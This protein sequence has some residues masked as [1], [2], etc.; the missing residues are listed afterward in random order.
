MSA[1]RSHSLTFPMTVTLRARSAEETAALARTVAPLLHPGDVLL[2]EGDI[3]AG[4]T[5]FAR[6]LIQERLRL[7]GEAVEDVPSPTFTLVQAYQ[8]G[9]DE[10]WH[11]DLY[12]LSDPDEAVELGLEDAFS[13]AICLVEWP[14][15]LGDLVP[16]DAAVLQFTS[17]ETEDRR[18]LAVRFPAARW[19]ACAKALGALA[20]TQ[21]QCQ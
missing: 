21:D 2:L 14:D 8:A 1:A 9:Q 6:A 20:D 16:E 19:A 18:N 13:T 15:R 7:A 17:G 5:H 12:R 3:G 10:I 11:S 4:K